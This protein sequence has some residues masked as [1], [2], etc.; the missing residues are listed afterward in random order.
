MEEIKKKLLYLLNHLTG[1]KSMVV[2]L[3]LGFLVWNHPKGTPFTSTEVI[4]AVSLAGVLI[5]AWAFEKTKK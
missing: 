3:T 2:I 4:A 5:G 1:K